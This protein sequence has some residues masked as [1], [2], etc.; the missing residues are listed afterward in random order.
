MNDFI[1]H[2][3]I[4][5]MKWGVRR[6]QPYG[7]GYDAEHKGR[8]VGQKPAKA[9]RR[10]HM[11]SKRKKPEIPSNAEIDALL[12]ELGEPVPETGTTEQDSEPQATRSNSA[13]T[14]AE[15]LIDTEYLDILNQVDETESGLSYVAK[16]LTSS[17]DVDTYEYF[18][19]RI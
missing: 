4:L 15:S 3:G 6:Y 16:L 12:R 5:G 1:K 19:D 18:L 17:G 10:K 7:E 2:H 8:F 9:T 13:E 11:L 14:F